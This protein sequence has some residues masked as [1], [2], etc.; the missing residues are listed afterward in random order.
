M[1]IYDFSSKS[2][3]ETS[4]EFASI[5]NSQIVT[6]IDNLMDE[7]DRI[8]KSFL[9]DNDIISDITNEKD[10]SINERINNQVYLRKIIMRLM[11][12]KP[13]IR[14]IMLLTSGNVLYQFSNT[15]DYVNLQ[16]LSGQPWLKNMIDSKDKLII[17]SVHDR[18]YYDNQRDGIALT[19]G[20]HILDYNG[21]Y[22][23]LLLID[24]EPSSLIELNDN[25]LLARNRYN[26][27][28]SIT[29]ETGGILY[30]SDVASGR[31]TWDEARNS[32]IFYDK[33]PEDFIIMTNNTKSGNLYVNAV[34][35]RSSLLFKIKKINYI[36]IIAIFICSLLVTGI[37]FYLS[38]TITKPLKKLQK[39]MKFVEDGQYTALLQG[40][41]GS[42]IGSLIVSY[43]NMITR[44]KTLIED[45]Y[46][47]EIKQKNAK[48]LALQTQINPHMLYNTLESIRMKALLRGED[49]IADMI[50]ILSKMFKSALS[51]RTASHYIQDELEYT[52]NYIMLQNI[53]FNNQFLMTVKLDE[54]IRKVSI[55]AMV[56][57]PIIEN[58]IEH[59]FYGHDTILSVLI[60]GTRT[61]TGDIIIRI[62][63][64]GKGMSVEKINDVN[65]LISTADI[66]KLEISHQMEKGRTSIGL[67]NIAERI[68]LYYGDAYYL[69]IF[70][71][72][73]KGTVVEMKI[74]DQN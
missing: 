34:I 5:Y 35:P 1:I 59:G 52:E 19:I 13:E 6:N 44:I 8:T 25:F 66:S 36:T 30:D 56:F 23:G 61:E 28:I 12:L 41:T 49:E 21:I 31:M 29:D 3:E 50:K 22:T 55:I 64:N 14:E 71:Y 57:Q 11:T 45:V 60:E 15:G 47:A 43:N 39:N 4:M 51:G 24:L 26:I 40:E 38:R 72:L 20:R 63:D 16:Y 2:L 70:S 68:K 37:S 67:K 42:E 10:V 48:F 46:M 17:T 18:S 74:P 58:S 73:D 65:N 27:K 62:S 53:R 7:Y 9:V 54:S 69:K 33:N 32:S